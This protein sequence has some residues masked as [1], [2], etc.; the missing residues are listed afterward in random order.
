MI[1]IVSC[2]GQF[3]RC[4]HLTETV[5]KCTLCTHLCVL[6]FSGVSPGGASRLTKHTQ[7]R[8][9]QKLTSDSGTFVPIFTD[10]TCQTSEVMCSQNNVSASANELIHP[11]E[12][13]LRLAGRVCFALYDETSSY[14]RDA[15]LLYLLN[16]TALNSLYSLSLPF[17]G[18]SLNQKDYHN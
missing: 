11:K 1:L 7:P 17:K 5:Y 8:N 18:S 3:L 2:T 10:I 16:V 12:G 9:T 13:P 14:F 6:D 15:S 4:T